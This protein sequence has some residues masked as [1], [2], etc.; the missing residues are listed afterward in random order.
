MSRQLSDELRTARDRVSSVSRGLA[1]AGLGLGTAGNV[2]DQVGELI[3][4]TP[5]G[6]AL[7]DLTADYGDFD[8]DAADALAAGTR[9]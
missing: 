3:A 2:S 4:I 5:T 1:A 6:A 9:A 8:L 7:K